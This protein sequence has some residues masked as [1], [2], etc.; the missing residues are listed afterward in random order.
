[1]LL[2][3]TNS[4]LGGGGSRPREFALLAKVIYYMN[5]GWQPEHGG[6]LL[7]WPADGSSPV[8]LSPRADRLV[9]FISSLEHQVLPA[10][11]PRY[12][13]TAWMYNRRDTALEALAEELRERKQKGRLDVKALLEALDSD[14]EDGGVDE[15]LDGAASVSEQEKS[16]ER[17]TARI[18]IK[19]I[20]QRKARQMSQGAAQ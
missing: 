7:L 11:A 9:L 18:V 1:M 16:V 4:A 14:D 10:W 2:K 19:Q 5:K 6:Q 12:A 13:L 20:M 17:C 15:S 3:K 8:E